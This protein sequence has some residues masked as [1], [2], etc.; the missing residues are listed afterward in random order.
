MA[1]LDMKNGD[2]GVVVGSR[3]LAVGAVAPYA[4]AG[5]GAV[6]TQSVANVTYG[7]NGL[8]QMAMGKSPE[9]V[10]EGLTS[11]DPHREL[12]QVG[13]V[14]AK[15][16]SFAFTGEQASDWKGHFYGEGFS[17]QGNLLAGEAVLSEMVRAFRETDGELSERLMAFPLSQK[18]PNFW[19][20]CRG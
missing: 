19:L 6:V 3:V 4:K 2:L 1:A 8:A 10:I 14:N 15:G 11:E 7:P 20:G 16:E 13:M 18:T 9:S 17:C 12:R 5:V